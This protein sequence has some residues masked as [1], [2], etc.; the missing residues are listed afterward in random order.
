MCLSTVLVLY[1]FKFVP[2]ASRVTVQ[3]KGPSMD[4][5]IKGGM[6]G[7]MSAKGG[8]SIKAKGGVKG[9]S[10]DMK[11]KGGATVKGVGLPERTC[12]PGCS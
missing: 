8:G 11:V 9:S 10:V 5:K 12:A 3:V 4:M 1:V 6:G 2:E 7:G